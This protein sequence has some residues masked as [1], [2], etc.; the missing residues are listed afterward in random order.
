M[1]TAED[2]VGIH[3]LLHG[4][5]LSTSQQKAVVC[6]VADSMID[7]GVVGQ[8]GFAAGISNSSLRGVVLGTFS[9]RS[10]KVV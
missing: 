8:R 4:V 3:F 6:L 5:L 7:G 9:R 10:R 2:M 1:V